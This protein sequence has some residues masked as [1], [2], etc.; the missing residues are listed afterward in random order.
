MR[1]AVTTSAELLCA[2]NFSG[3]L[4]VDRAGNRQRHKCAVREEERI[5]SGYI[6]YSVNRTNITSVESGENDQ[7]C[8]L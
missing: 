4:T 5:N 6:E 7:D 2:G 8:D 1:R 3:Q